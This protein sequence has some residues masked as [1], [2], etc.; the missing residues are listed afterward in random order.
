[1]KTLN[2]IIEPAR[3]LLTWQ[4]LDE[5]SKSRTRRIIGEVQKDS[6]GIVIFHYLKNTL[7]YEEAWKAGFVGYP[8]FST[9]QD[10]FSQGV[11]Q[12]LM[13]RIPSRQRE[14]FSDYLAQHRLPA[15]FDYSDMALLGYTGARLPSDGFALIPVFPAD[16]IPCD[17]L[18][19]VAGL[20]YVYFQSIN[21]IQ[22]GDLVTFE[23]EPGNLVDPD[24]LAVMHKGHR[25]GYVNRAMK[26]NFHGWLR[27]H[28]ITATVERI[29]G[30][31]E[32]PL[33][34]VRVSVT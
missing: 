30:K 21:N 20:R 19:E 4:P 17:L 28:H 23:I 29:N 33:V 16:K 10:K 9:Q 11:I 26:N 18:M 8:S 2:H 24:A 34:Y 5:Q 14:D 13:R 27:D 7:D 1:M 12:S 22:A 25:I 6:D 15:P 31:P 32:R 3:L